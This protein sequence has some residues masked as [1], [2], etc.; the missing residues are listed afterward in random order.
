MKRL[1]SCCLILFITTSTF[2][3]INKYF[4]YFVQVPY[5][6]DLKNKVSNY[7]IDVNCNLFLFNC[8][9]EYKYGNYQ[10]DNSGSFYPPGYDFNFI[11]RNNSISGFIGLG[12][13]SYFQFQVGYSSNHYT[14]LRL[15]S[16]WRFVD[17]GGGNYYRS[18]FN[19]IFPR[20]S[21]KVSIDK[22]ITQ[23][24]KA[25]WFVSAGIGYSWGGLSRTSRL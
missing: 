1:L 7:G 13:L 8:G 24:H 25:G 17:L 15:L 10:I 3:Q 5:T 6:Y 22:T 18:K 16:E 9:I 20:A 4:Q 11:G 19:Q 2:G 23:V 12:A 21:F 14:L